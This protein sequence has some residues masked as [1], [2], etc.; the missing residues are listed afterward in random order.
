MD[1]EKMKDCTFK[2][3]I[4]KKNLDISH[5]SSENMPVVILI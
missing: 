5:K 2:P 3:K 4:N 1:E